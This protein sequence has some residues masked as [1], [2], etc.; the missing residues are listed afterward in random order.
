MTLPLR[1]PTPED[2]IP[3]A[4]P[5]TQLRILQ[6]DSTHRPMAK[7][8][9]SMFSQTDFSDDLPQQVT[10]VSF[11]RPTNSVAPRMELKD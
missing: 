4:D 10:A 6:Q 11:S 3:A 5:L 1:A 9:G 8:N 7:G 2:L